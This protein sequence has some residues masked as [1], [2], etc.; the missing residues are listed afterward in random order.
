MKIAANLSGLSIVLLCLLYGVSFAEG[1]NYSSRTDLKP[2]TNLID[3]GKY[4]S[5]IGELNKELEADPDNA[6]LLSLLGFSYRKTG[7]FDDAL[8]YYQRALKLEP[9]H[10]G[11]NEYL[12]QLYLETDQLDKAI[13]QLEILDDLCFFRCK[14]YTKL[15]KAIDNYQQ[16]ASNS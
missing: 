16:P 9:K 5:A 11:A 10:R 14:E 2:F 15:K 12:G 3:A 4:E 1:G 13:R 8:V 6:D 7:N